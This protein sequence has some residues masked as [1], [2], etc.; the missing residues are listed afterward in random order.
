[1][2]AVSTKCPEPPNSISNKAC[3]LMGSLVFYVM[4]LA[5]FGGFH[6]ALRCLLRMGGRTTPGRANFDEPLGAHL[7]VGA[8]FVIGTPSTVS[9][10]SSST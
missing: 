7:L 8:S 1:M 4:I 5:A 6:L 2:G 9:F 10:P 3:T